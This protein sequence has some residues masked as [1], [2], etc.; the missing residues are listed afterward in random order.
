MTKEMEK[1]LFTC[2]DARLRELE[3]LKSISNNIEDIEKEITLI[4]SV[5]SCQKNFGILN[6]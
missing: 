6:N 2:F 3:A 5:K 1:L 4:K